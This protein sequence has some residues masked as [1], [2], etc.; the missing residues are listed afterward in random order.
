M[1][2]FFITLYLLANI[3]LGWWMSRRVKTT[4][5]FVNAG[6]NLPLLV[7]A[8]TF[9]ATWFGSETV[10]G[11]SAEFV[12]HGFLGIIEDPFGSAL[13]FFLVGLF[14]A[15][16]LYKL[17]I[18]TFN[19][20]FKIRFN[21]VIEFASAFFMIPSY[22]GW[23]AAQLLA[24]AI[25][26][27]VLMGIPIF[28]GIVICTF[29]VVLYTYFGGMWA[30]SIT[31]FV[32]TIVIVLGLLALSFSMYQQLDTPQQLTQNLPKDFFQFFPDSDFHS[33]THYLAAWMVIGLGSIPQQ[34]IFQ[35][36]VAAKSAN[37]AVRASHLGGLLYL[38]VAMLPLFIALCSKALH[39]ELQ[40]EDAQLIL[41][42][43]VLQHS[44]VLLQI[45]FFGALLSAIL[46]TASGGILAPATVVGENLIKPFRKDLSDQQLLRI[47]RISVIGIA[48][49]AMLM[50]FGSDSIFEMVAQ[51]STISLVALF[52]PLTAG[53]YWKQANNTG[54]LLSI[55]AGVVVWL[56][57]EW[58]GSAVPSLIWGL[59][60]SLLGMVLGSLINRRN[61]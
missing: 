12:Q 41:P 57:F 6:R 54:A 40:T 14:Y 22:I 53:L 35:R 38:S 26:L 29:A 49:A 59:L 61:L 46:S 36:V 1:L 24:L 18:L 27:N 17:D 51:S 20:Y 44:N 5:D 48:L 21:R 28:Y 43:T 34:V 16:P 31:S 3:A 9:F 39:P 37:T 60:A 45:L 19:D 55:V 23:I 42:M 4:S 10:L 30:V 52:V 25:L 47:M 32:Q 56:L 50:A 2:L 8:C 13:C 33:I 11:A 58:M 15:R 7:A